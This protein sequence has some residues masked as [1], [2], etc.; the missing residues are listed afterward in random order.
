MQGC[1]E[2]ISVLHQVAVGN[3]NQDQTPHCCE[4]Q[5]HEPSRCCFAPRHGVASCIMLSTDPVQ[6]H[7]L[8]L[9]CPCKRASV[10]PHGLQHRLHA[11]CSAQFFKRCSDALCNAAL[12]V[13]TYIHTHNNQY[14]C[15]NNMSTTLN[16]LRAWQQAAVRTGATQLLL[17]KDM[18]KAVQK[19]WKCI[20]R[21][22]KSNTQLN[23]LAVSRG[24]HTVPLKVTIRLNQSS[25]T[26]LSMTPH[27]QQW[28]V[29][30]SCGCCAAELCAA[31][32]K[33]SSMQEQ[34]H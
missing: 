7:S 23:T 20:S 25:C 30:R 1:L 14:I 18:S 32:Q 6:L 16:P 19:N 21:S 22:N 8:V 28:G 2:R 31:Q 24:L 26:L 34:R 10:R 5:Q 13:C 11:A 17:L 9:R 15:I 27:A 4:K 3:M 12:I 33:C 29:L